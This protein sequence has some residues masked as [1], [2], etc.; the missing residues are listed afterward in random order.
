MKRSGR[1]PGPSASRSNPAAGRQSAPW[2]RLSWQ[3]PGMTRFRIVSPNGTSKLYQGTYK[4]YPS[5]VLGVVPKDA[6][7]FVLSPT[8]WL[9]ITVIDA[10]EFSLEALIQQD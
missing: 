7:P 8:G 1:M 2:G 3:A 10:P 9:Q 6:S 5:G 4:V